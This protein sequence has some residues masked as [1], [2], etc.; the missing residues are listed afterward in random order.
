LYCQEDALTAEADLRL[1]ME[2]DGF[3]V[4]GGTE[5]LGSRRRELG[6]DSDKGA[7]Q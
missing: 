4:E 5:K 2:A 6:I 7:T 3:V 1:A